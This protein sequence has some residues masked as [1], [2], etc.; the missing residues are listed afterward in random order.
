MMM[1]MRGRGGEGGPSDAQAA[2]YLKPPSASPRNSTRPN[3]HTK[4]INQPTNKKKAERDAVPA[5]ARRRALRW[6]E[7]RRVHERGVRRG[8]DAGRRR[9]RHRRL[10]G[11]A[12]RPPAARVCRRERRRRGAAVAGRRVGS[13]VEAVCECRGGG[14]VPASFVRDRAGGG[15]AAAELVNANF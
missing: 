2:L 3:T 9:R 15:A 11:A 13:G 4:N 6:L 8:V 1:M 7:Q 12:R 10:E 14:L 5:A